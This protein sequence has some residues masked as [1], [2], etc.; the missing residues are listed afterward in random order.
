MQL[1]SLIDVFAAAL[2]MAIPCRASF[3]P[4][5]MLPFLSKRAVMIRFG[6]FQRVRDESSFRAVSNATTNTSKGDIVLPT[7]EYGYRTSPF[8]WTELVHII[9]VEK[10]L[11][12]LSRSVKQQTAYQIH[13]HDLKSTWRDPHHYILHS[14][15][16]LEKRLVKSTDGELWETDPPV[17][18]I[19]PR[20]NLSLND[21][22]YF[23]APAIYH[24]VLWKI[25]GDVTDQEIEHARQQIR[26][27][28]GD[29]L[30]F[31]QWKNPLH[32]KSLPDIDHAHILVHTATATNPASCNQ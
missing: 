23:T 29:V 2:M 7:R 26:S 10:N 1:R 17:A 21:F 32:L 18:T 6:P 14:K 22:P 30:D 11:A 31:L 8:N 3:L 5:Q 15:F 13:L 28:L 12:K 16:G 9:K 24:Y 4:K 27:E 19:E 25:G 20:L